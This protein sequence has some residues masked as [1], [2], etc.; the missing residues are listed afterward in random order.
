MNPIASSRSL[1]NMALMVASDRAPATTERDRSQLPVAPKKERVFFYKLNQMRIFPALLVFVTHVEFY[2]AY[3]GIIP[4]ESVLPLAH[5]GHQSLSFFFVLSGFLITYLMLYEQ[6]KTGRVNIRNFYARRMLRVW[7]LYYLILAIAFFVVPWVFHYNPVK[8]YIAV[9]CRN[10][11]LTH[12]VNALLL[13]IFILPNVSLARKFYVNCG[14]QSWTVGVEEQ[15]YLFWPLLL[16]MCRKRPWLMMLGSIFCKLLILSI[17]DAL[18]HC[19]LAV[20]RTHLTDTLAKC[21]SFVLRFDVEGLALGSIGAYLLLYKPQS[22]FVRLVTHTVAW[23]LSFAP[24]LIIPTLPPNEDWLNYGLRDFCFAICYACL[25]I[26]LA[27]SSSALT[28]GLGKLLNYLGTI[29]YGFYMYHILAICIL[30][31]ILTHCKG[32]ND[33]GILFNVLLYTGSL[34]LALVFSILS[35]EFYE[36]RFLKLKSRFSYV[37]T[38]PAPQTTG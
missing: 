7:P 9:A 12:F 35:Y 10:K 14:G 2:K 24:L 19:A 13:Y 8:A 21:T 1:E 5:W 34:A 30:L 32:M 11:L 38:D 36:S 27:K 25:I 3:V 28:T 33:C 29:C 15:F 23:V 18:S 26:K 6:L 17:F 37:L 31:E 4:L 22:L 16:S 20:N